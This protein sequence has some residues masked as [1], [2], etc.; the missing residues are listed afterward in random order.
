[1]LKE[2]ITQLQKLIEDGKRINYE[3]D[4]DYQRKMD[5]LQRN[6]AEYEKR[7]RML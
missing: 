3:N 4:K 2:N 7:E 5:Y 1:M 6:I